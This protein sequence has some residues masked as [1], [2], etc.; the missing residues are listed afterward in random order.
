MRP[1]GEVHGV[2]RALYTAEHCGEKTRQSIYNRAEREDI[3]RGVYQRVIADNMHGGSH[4][5]RNKCIEHDEQSARKIEHRSYSYRR[6]EQ[7]EA[8]EEQQKV[9]GG[10]K[11]A[12]PCGH[13]AS[14][15]KRR[16]YRDIAEQSAECRRTEPVLPVLCAADDKEQ[17]ERE[18]GRAREH[19]ELMLFGK[20]RKCRDERKRSQETAE[21]HGEESESVIHREVAY[22]TYNK[23]Q[24]IR[25][26]EAPEE[27]PGQLPEY[28]RV[29]FHLVI[30]RVVRAA[31]Q[32][33]LRNIEHRTDIGY[34]RYVG[35]AFARL[36]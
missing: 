13:I 7:G 14:E 22:E 3:D 32:L 20:A 10:N 19:R 36:P 12:F 25:A 15:Q 8:G 18:I 11:S 16:E 24:R 35:I 4:R 31:Y 9:Y 6:N 5:K 21:N 34:H 29:P 28:A 17:D 1:V 27:C 26:R 23:R 30:L 2:V 33:M